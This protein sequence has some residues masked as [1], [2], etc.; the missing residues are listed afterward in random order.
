MPQDWTSVSPLAIPELMDLFRQIQGSIPNTAGQDVSNY[1]GQ[2]MNSPLLQ[3]ILEPQLALLARKQ[4][5]QMQQLTDAFRASGGLRGSE[6]GKAVPRLQG[7]QGLAQA[8]LISQL[9]SQTLSPMLTALNQ[10]TQNQFLPVNALLN[11]FGAARPQVNFGNGG[12]GGQGGQGGGAP[13]MNQNPFFSGYGD[14]MMQQQGAPQPNFNPFGGNPQPQQGGGGFDPFAGGAAQPPQAAAPG[15]GYNPADFGGGGGASTGD[16]GGFY[17]DPL[18]GQW[19]QQPA[20]SALQGNPYG[21]NLDYGGGFGVAQE[22]DPWAYFND[23][24]WGF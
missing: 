8:D 20:A 19:T 1:L 9:T 13:S 11:L 21:A 10:Q 2:G 23:N 3:S 17:Q 4:Q 18:S 22:P 14:Q 7:D 16:M 15:G 5:P 12:G 24:N 6:Y